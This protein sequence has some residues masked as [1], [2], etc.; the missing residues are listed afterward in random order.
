VRCFGAWLL[1]RFEFCLARRGV[2]SNRSA[3]LWS[4][5][6]QCFC[7]QNH[8]TAQTR[9]F[10]KSRTAGTPHEGG[11]FETGVE[12]RRELFVDAASRFLAPRESSMLLEVLNFALV[13]LGLLQ[14]RKRAEVAA[15][16]G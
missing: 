6:G 12:F 1:I 11:D 2:A 14:G 13:L 3:S 8:P 4:G 15:F 7:S 16:S 9:R 10:S 5:F